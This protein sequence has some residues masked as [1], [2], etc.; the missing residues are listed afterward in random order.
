MMTNRMFLHFD[1]HIDYSTAFR[2]CCY[3]S[4][5]AYSLSHSPYIYIYMRYACVFIRTMCVLFGSLCWKWT[6]EIHWTQLC[7]LF[8]VANSLYYI[9]FDFLLSRMALFLS[10][11]GFLQFR[12][13]IE[14]HRCGGLNWKEWKYGTQK[15]GHI[16]NMSAS[17]LETLAK[18]AQFSNYHH[19]KRK[20]FNPFPMHKQKQTKIE[21]LLHYSLWTAPVQLHSLCWCCCHRHLVLSSF[22]DGCFKHGTTTNTKTQQH[23]VNYACN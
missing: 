1:S 19:Q 8:D 15:S 2:W 13:Y 3:C 18:N 5:L 7:V 17:L 16:F 21:S 4:L 22:T 20:P 6:V 23:I 10:L 9:N 14:A 12:P 11:S